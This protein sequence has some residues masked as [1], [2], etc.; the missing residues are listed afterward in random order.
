[1]KNL[2]GLA[3]VFVSST[4]AA[5]V[6]EPVVD[7][8]EIFHAAYV[9]DFAVDGDMGKGVWGKAQ[10]VPALMLR[11]GEKEMPFKSEIRLLWSKTAIYIGATLWQDMANMVCKWDQRDQAIWDDDN[12][13]IFLYAPTEKGNRLYQF[14]QNPIDALADLCDGNRGYWTRGSKHATKRFGDRWT[15]ELKL[16]FDGIPMERPVVGDFIG[17]RFCRSVHAPKPTT[18]ARPAMMSPGH[19]QRKRFAKFLFEPPAGADAVNTIAECEDYR[20]ETLRKRFYARFG[21]NKARFAEVRGCMSAFAQSKHPIHERAR[22]G[23]RQMGNALA[24]FEKKFADDIAAERSIPDNEAE[25]ILVQ[26]AN[27]WEFA[28]KY[29]YMVWE[30]SPWERGSPNDLPPKDATFMPDMLSFEQAGNEREQ[31]CL[32]ISGVLCGPRLDLRL[33]PESVERTK[34]SPFVSTDN[35][36]IYA[37]PFVRFGGDV[38]TAPLVRTPGNAVTISPGRTIRVWV[39]FNSRGVESGEYSTRL[40]LKSANDLAVEDRILPV[41]VKVWNF[42][43]PETRNWP[44]KSFAWG[45]WSFAD[46]EVALLELMH[47]RHFTH[48]WVNKFHWQYGLYDDFGCYRKPCNGKGK[49]AKTHDFEDGLALHGNEAFLR[50]AKELGMR[51]VVGWGTPNSVDWFKTMTKRFLDMGLGY[52]DFV[53]HGLLRDEFTK[54][55]ITNN[56]A[57]R[58]A[59]WNWNTNLNFLATYL[60]TPPPTGATMDDIEAAKLPDFFKQW[61]VIN[62]RCR[63]PKEGPDTIGRLKAKG[64]KVWTYNCAQFMQ[65]HSILGYYRFYP[66]DAYMRNLEGFAFWTAYS[67]NGDDGWDSRDGH[68]E[69]LCWRGLDKKPI[70]TKMLEAVREGL[71]DVAYMAQLERIGGDDAKV[72]LDARE[73]VFKSKD[74]RRLDA[75]RLAAGRFIDSRISK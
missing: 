41:G 25:V 30:T 62:S 68:D 58:D 67:P 50:R 10:P 64:C 45:S 28:S 9:E 75:W 22:A 57:S 5:S 43:L 37:E 55:E 8:D 31:V 29:A 14:V 51:F 61:A 35:F 39:M 32:N 36:E 48:G 65:N 6:L 34:K 4:I 11:G 21:E 52:D 63:D 47:S 70:P 59:V 12:I 74:Q 73:N 49:V 33:H 71:E 53:F 26:F 46:D 40:S 69:G 7:T 3:T 54:A 44:I 1:M 42:A 60:S 38:I 18:G 72:L 23:V 24:A 15:M 17:V 20:K 2:L 13:E 16:P 19:A 56:V 27:F 66:W